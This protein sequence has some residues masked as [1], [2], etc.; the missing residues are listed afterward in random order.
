[1]KGWPQKLRLISHPK[2]VLVIAGVI[3]SIAIACSGSGVTGIA[4]ADPQFLNHVDC[5]GIDTR[6]LPAEQIKLE[7]RDIELRIGA[8]IASEAPQRTQGFMCRSGIAAGT[9]MYFELPAESIRGFWMFNTYVP[10]DIL[11]LDP[12]GFT[13]EIATLAPCP[14]SSGG[15]DPE[16]DNEWRV[17]CAAEAEPH[18]PTDHPYLDVLELP[19]GWLESQGIPL[20]DAIELLVVIRR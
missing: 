2:V 10:L 9:G 20:E 5:Q 13:V 16:T 3:V 6:P 1:M 17:R 18:A 15:P 7:Y 12:D 14:R 8:E 19:A 11:Y 4:L